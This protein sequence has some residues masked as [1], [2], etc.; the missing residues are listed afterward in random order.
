MCSFHPA[1]LPEHLPLKGTGF[2]LVFRGVSWL[3]HVLGTLPVPGHIALLE[4]QSCS[5]RSCGWVGVGGD[6]ARCA[7]TMHEEMSVMA[8][9]PGYDPKQKGFYERTKNSA[10]FLVECKNSNRQLC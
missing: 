2:Q 7:G 4:K 3:F 1:E 10:C 6:T 5:N 8:A 9:G